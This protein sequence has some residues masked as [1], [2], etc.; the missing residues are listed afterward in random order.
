MQISFHG[1]I[2]DTVFFQL[3]LKLVLIANIIEGTGW[4]TQ[5]I[6]NCT[7]LLFL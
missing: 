4:A 6:V 3:T 5:I 7:K 2:I 1:K